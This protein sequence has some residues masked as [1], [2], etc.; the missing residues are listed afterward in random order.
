MKANIG[1]AVKLLQIIILF[2]I[3]FSYAMFQGGFVSWF[4][5]YSF[6]PLI[7][8]MLFLLFYPIS[9]WSVSRVLSKRIVNAGDDVKVELEIKRKFAFPLIYLVV[10]EYFP[11]T[12]QYKDLN[13]QKFKD[14]HETSK[15]VNQRLLKRVTFPWFKRTIH[16]NYTLNDLPRGEHHLKAFRIK[17]GDFFGFIKKDYIYEC[18]NRLIVYPQQRSVSIKEKVNSFEE[19][20]T[21]SYASNQ[22]RTSVVA[23]VREYMPGDRFSWIDWKT[24]ARKN[25][26]MTKEFEQEKSANL[27]FIL[28]TIDYSGMNKISFEAAIEFTS[29]IMETLRKNSAQIAF[30]AIGEKPSYFP[31]NQDPSKNTM[32]QSYLAKVQPSGDESFPK[33][34]IK[35]AKRMP[36]GLVTIVTITHLSLKMQLSLEQLQQK[37]KRVIVYLIKPKA[38]VTALDHQIMHDLSVRGIVVHVLSEDQ[39]IQHEFEVTM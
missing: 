31:F 3:F 23:G 29:S 16:L 14:M 20:S 22:S 32:I 6:L 1:F 36:D 18:E 11:P 28:D 21:P 39:L 25:T 38:A 10:E 35:Q 37:S 33:K 30:L 2:A 27:L 13:R 5:F 34:L 24:T 12:L 26:I 19:G 15:L 9:K 7:I 4:L 8:H 17:T